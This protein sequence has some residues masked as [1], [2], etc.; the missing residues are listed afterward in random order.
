[1]VKTKKKC[2]G[3]LR[4]QQKNGGEGKKKKQ[5]EIS[6]QSTREKAKFVFWTTQV[7]YLLK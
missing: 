4:K 6:L 2:Q 5:E 7:N 1:M 3:A